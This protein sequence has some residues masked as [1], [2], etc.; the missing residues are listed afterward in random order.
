[1]HS[2]FHRKSES[3]TEGIG[4]PVEYEFIRCAGAGTKKKRRI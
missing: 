2:G 4:T 1:M 3:N